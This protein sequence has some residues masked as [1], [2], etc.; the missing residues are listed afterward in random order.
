MHDFVGYLVTSF[1][2]FVGIACRELPS[3]YRL[4]GYATEWA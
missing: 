4:P 1:M 2:M 3:R